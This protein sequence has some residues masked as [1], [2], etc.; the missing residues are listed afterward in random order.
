MHDVQDEDG[1]RETDQIGARTRDVYPFCFDTNKG[2]KSACQKHQSPSDREPRGDLWLDR[3]TF[4]DCIIGR[5]DI[6]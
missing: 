3:E 2:I 1:D 5:C 4:D 6:Q